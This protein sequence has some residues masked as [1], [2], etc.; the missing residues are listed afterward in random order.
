MA[1]VR[2]AVA[3]VLLTGAVLVALG[4]AAHAAAPSGRQVPTETIIVPPD[5][6]DND[7]FP[8]IPSKSN[9]QP[10][11]T[12]PSTEPPADEP[13]D[14]TVPG[15]AEP[16]AASPPE[17]TRAQRLPTSRRRPSNT[18]STSCRRR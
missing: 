12:A 2:G 10:A 9:D 14:A 6:G 1:K 7:A 15:A 3:G 5:N 17:E 16:D 13:P 18:M 4:L 11:A 8:D